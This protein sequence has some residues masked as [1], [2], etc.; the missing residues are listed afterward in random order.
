MEN[1][2]TPNEKK[3]LLSAITPDMLILKENIKQVRGLHTYETPRLI[4]ISIPPFPPWPYGTK[5]FA[6]NLSSSP[7]VDYIFV[8]FD[9]KIVAFSA[10]G[11]CSGFW[12]SS[13]TKH[14][15]F[16]LSGTEVVELFGQPDEVFEYASMAK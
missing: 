4:Y 1:E 6:V 9:N 14:Y 16:P 10:L 2:Q 12:D 15:K 3:I 11:T 13:L 5:F 7:S 8:V